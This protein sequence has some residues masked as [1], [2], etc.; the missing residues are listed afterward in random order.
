MDS[1]DINSLKDANGHR[2]ILV[3]IDYFTIWAEAAFFANLTKMQVDEVCEKYITT[4]SYN[5][6]NARNLNND[7]MT[8]FCT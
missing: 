1:I 7:V 3:A 2:F 5:P 4:S 6:N 8:N